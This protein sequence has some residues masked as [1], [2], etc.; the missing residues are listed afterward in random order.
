[1]RDEFSTLDIVKALDI[2]RERL[3]DWMNKGFV[4]PTTPAEGQGTKAI[5][6]RGD[7][8]C[9]AL[10]QRLLE[11]GFKREDASRQVI[12][13]S[14]YPSNIELSNIIILPIVRKDG[15]LQHSDF[16]STDIQ[17]EYIQQQYA[18]IKLDQKSTDAKIDM[19]LKD[20]AVAK[21]A[22]L[23]EASDEDY[24]DRDTLKMLHDRK[25]MYKAMIKDYEAQLKRLK[26]EDY[27]LKKVIKRTAMPPKIA[28]ERYFR[29]GVYNQFGEEWEHVHIINYKNIRVRVDMALSPLD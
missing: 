12:I 10:F 2:P 28:L 19:L 18:E 8:Y 25:L 24:L 23:H 14:E 6:T 29:H 5:F 16:P 27:S 11:V 21:T 20:L 3:R 22:L 9:V 26:A 4:K 7:V 15:K 13:F 17:D 1:M